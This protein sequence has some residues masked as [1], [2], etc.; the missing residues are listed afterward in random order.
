MSNLPVLREYQFRGRGVRCGTTSGRPWVVAK[1][2]CESAGIVQAA[3]ALRDF[4]EGTEKGMQTVHT[5]AGLQR[6][7]VLYE[8]GLYRLIFQSRKPEAEAFKRWVFH[9]VLPEIQ[10]TGAYRAKQREKYK[11]LGQSDDWVDA[12]EAGIEERK[13]YCDTLKAHG[14]N[15]V[16]FAICTNEMYMGLFQNTAKG[17]LARKGLHQR[18]KLRDHM[19]AGELSAV[20]LSEYAARDKIDAERLYGADKCAKASR[21][22][23]DVIRQALDI[24]RRTPIDRPEGEA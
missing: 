20:R 5:P 1:D 16:G 24:I 3:S 12:R 15:G 17:L 10:R 7:L 6:M 18:A 4:E 23:G 21:M 11:T 22:S 9:E 19:D 13:T 2:A 14:V 8:P